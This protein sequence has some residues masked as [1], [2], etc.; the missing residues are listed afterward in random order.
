M[1]SDRGRINRIFYGMDI[2]ISSD[3]VLI[4]DLRALVRLSRC[5]AFSQ[6]QVENKQVLVLKIKE[7]II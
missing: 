7:K 3:R 5:L 1:N 4:S 6:N 2:E